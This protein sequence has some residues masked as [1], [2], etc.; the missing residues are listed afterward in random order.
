LRSGAWP[1]QFAILHQHSECRFRG[2]NDPLTVVA[3]YDASFRIIHLPDGWT[4][5]T[6]P[7]L[8][9][10]V[11][12]LVHH[13]QEIAGMTFECPEAREKQA[14]EAQARW[15]GLFQNDLQIAFGIDPFTMLVRTTCTY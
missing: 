3:L 8:S 15:L 11:H 9:V 10:L 7:E 12:E 2:A 6:G 5:T 13:L 4:G 14:Y 1:L